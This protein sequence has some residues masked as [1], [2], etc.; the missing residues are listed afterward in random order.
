MVAGSAVGS[1]SIAGSTG[2]VRELE[3]FLDAVG[4]QRTVQ[5]TTAPIDAAPRARARTEIPMSLCSSRATSEASFDPRGDGNANDTRNAVLSWLEKQKVRVDF[6]DDSPPPR[7]P[8][9]PTPSTSS[10]TPSACERA[11]NFNRNQRK[12]RLGQ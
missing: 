5:K 2:A 3:V 7:R 6:E 4:A 12:K 9:S 1:H 11:R 10:A 8:P